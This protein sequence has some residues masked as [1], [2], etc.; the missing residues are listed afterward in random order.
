[1]KDKLLNLIKTYRAEAERQWTMNT[2]NSCG[3]A[4]TWDKC[5][6]DLEELVRHLS[7]KPTEAKGDVGGEEKSMTRNE[8]LEWC[9]QRALKYVDMD[10]TSQAWSSMLSD[11]RTH[12]ETANHSAL[13]SGMMLLMAGQLSSPSKMRE[14]IVGFN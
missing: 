13:K 14:F 4:A 2:A 10:D 9:K 8:H 12:P 11:M 3:R 7:P 6:D 5:A 1:M